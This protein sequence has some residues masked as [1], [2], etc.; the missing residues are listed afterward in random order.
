MAS[1]A[2]RAF[3]LVPRHRTT[4]IAYGTQRSLRRGQGAEIAGT[5][6]YRPGDRLAWIDWYSSA[7]L[8]LARNDDQFVVRQYNA[9]TAPRVILVID[10]R[11]SMALFPPGLP[12]LA[13]PDVLREA[14][15]AIVAAAH[16]ARAYVG[17]LDISGGAE[18]ESGTPHW[19]S[20]HRQ[21]ARQILRRLSEEFNA[22]ADNLE[23][24]IDYL[25]GLRRDVPAG[26][27]VFV[28]SDFLRPGP[29]HIWSRARA[30]G[31]DL[32]PVIVQDRI[33]EQSFPLIEGLLL[34]VSDPETG[35]TGSVRLSANETQARRSENIARLERL[36]AMFRSLRFDPVLLDT[37]EPTAIDL[38][39]IEWASRRR[40]NR[41]NV[42]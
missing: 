14:A 16:G 18:H 32:V 15:T 1:R 9:E 5:R 25:L 22:P 35:K 40:L 28:V 13:K 7:R 41:S 31:W 29:D 2:R 17:Y 39:F 12:W 36:R 10:R 20:P 8:S 42:R 11:P 30:R 37:S 21:S 26:S 24:A 38:A 19:I 4:G 23:V 6:P 3:P 34:P 27:F 33:W